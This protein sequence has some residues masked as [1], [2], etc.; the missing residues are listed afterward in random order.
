ML[1]TWLQ[2]AHDIAMRTACWYRHVYRVL[3]HAL[4]YSTVVVRA[5]A[6]C[7]PVSVVVRADAA[8]AASPTD[9]KTTFSPQTQTGAN[10]CQGGTLHE[11]KYLAR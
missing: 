5:D 3:S 6:A 1:Q 7:A 2:N 9:R 8:C 10:W 11:N 4:R